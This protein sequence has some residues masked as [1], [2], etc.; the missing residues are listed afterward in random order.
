MQTI[1]PYTGQG[2]VGQWPGKDF[3]F[4]CIIRISSTTTTTTMSTNIPYNEWCDGIQSHGFFNHRI[5]IGHLSDIFLAYR[6][7]V[8]VTGMIM[9]MIQNM[10]GNFSV[11]RFLNLW[12]QGQ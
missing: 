6:D 5:E 12:I 1:D 4:F 3:G 10:R 2:V 8:E 9:I 11:Q 7:I